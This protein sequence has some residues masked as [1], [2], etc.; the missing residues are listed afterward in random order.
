MSEREVMETKIRL[1]VLLI[2]TS[3]PCIIILVFLYLF[4]FCFYLCKAVFQEG[5]K[6]IMKMYIYIYIVFH[7]GVEA[8]PNGQGS[9]AFW[10]PTN[11]TFSPILALPSATAT[12]PYSF[13]H[14]H[15][16]PQNLSHSYCFEI[17]YSAI[18]TSSGLLPET[19]VGCCCFQSSNKVYQLFLILISFFGIF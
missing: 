14:H 7:G 16:Q 6:A 19:S 2:R 8:G 4:L 17:F 9:K 3:S 18:R 10:A 1:S 13:K 11:T 12:P 15:H 5:K